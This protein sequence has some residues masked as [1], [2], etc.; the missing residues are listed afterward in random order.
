M[1]VRIVSDGSIMGTRV[2]GP[3]GIDLGRI[4]DRVD[5]QHSGGDIPRADLSLTMVEFEYEG[6]ARMVGPNGKAVRRIEY[7]DGTVDTFDG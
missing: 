4:I 1:K 6:R 7:Q 2:E 5:F 3:D